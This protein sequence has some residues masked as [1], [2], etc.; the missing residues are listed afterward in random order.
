MAIAAMALTIFALV[1]L[2]TTGAA[3]QADKG[4]SIA[5][6]KQAVNKLR[7]AANLVY[8]QGPP[9]QVK[10]SVSVPRDTTLFNASGREIVMVLGTPPD[11]STVYSV[12]YANLSANG[13]VL[14][15]N[16]PGPQSVI[17]A[18]VRQNGNVIVQLNASS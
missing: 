13:L 14:A 2:F 17:V 9:S 8:T 11:D 1:W 6:A 4:A 12:T 15:G 5:T 7:D 3:S 10:V 18:A 16:S